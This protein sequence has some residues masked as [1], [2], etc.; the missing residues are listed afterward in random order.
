MTTDIISVPMYFYFFRGIQ[1]VA[2]AEKDYTEDMMNQLIQ[3][4]Y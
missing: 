2:G 1:V 3:M 4:R